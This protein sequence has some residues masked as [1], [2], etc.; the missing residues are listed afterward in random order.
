M[1]NEIIYFLYSGMRETR[2]FGNR[3]SRPVS[4][5]AGPPSERRASEPGALSRK[6]RGT[7]SS[8]L[9]GVRPRRK[10]VAAHDARTVYN[11]I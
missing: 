10:T 5:N 1:W 11:Y 3:P 2:K 7:I 6:L 8:R 4:L 9:G